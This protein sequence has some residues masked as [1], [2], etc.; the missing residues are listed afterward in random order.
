LQPRTALF[1]IGQRR[2]QLIAPRREVRQ[3][4]GQFGEGFFRSRKRG[5]GL[6]DAGI[7]PGQALGAGMGFGGERGLLEIEPVQRRFGVV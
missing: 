6:R 3:R 5:I 2:L 1:V 4:A 7:D